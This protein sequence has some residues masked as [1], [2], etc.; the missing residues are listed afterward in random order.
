MTQGGLERYRTY[1]QAHIEKIRK[2]EPGVCIRDFSDE[3]LTEFIEARLT[4]NQRR[5]VELRFSEPFPTLKTIGEQMGVRRERIR[6]LLE[7]SFN[8]FMRPESGFRSD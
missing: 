2:A 8:R 6:Q 7:E 1:I 4:E 5:A 3:E